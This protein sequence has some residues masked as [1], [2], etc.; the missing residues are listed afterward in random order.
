MEA[1]AWETPEETIKALADRVRDVY[2][3]QTCHTKKYSGDYTTNNE[4]L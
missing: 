2:K 3:R 1:L 4:C